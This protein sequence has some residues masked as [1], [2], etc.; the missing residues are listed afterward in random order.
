RL[1]KPATSLS[2][3]RTE[4]EPYPSGTDADGITRENGHCEWF[5]RDD[6]QKV[7]VYLQ[8]SG[9]VKKSEG[10]L[11][12]MPWIATGVEANVCRIEKER[13]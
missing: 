3:E 11:D 1:W 7:T 6:L 10:G 5:S 2:V 4:C 8:K 12:K 9:D 13:H